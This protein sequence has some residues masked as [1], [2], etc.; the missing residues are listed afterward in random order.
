MLI[1]KK[2]MRG[3]D[4]PFGRPESG[5]TS[6][7]NASEGSENQNP[8][9]EV[10]SASEE[11]KGGESEWDDVSGSE[12]NQEA[13]NSDAEIESELHRMREEIQAEADLPKLREVDF[14]NAAEYGGS[15]I[16]ATFNAV[17]L[18]CASYLRLLELG[19]QVGG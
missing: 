9:S 5:K 1:E 8:G 17:N 10:E 11:N 3:W 2:Q 18:L 4:K 7:K 14:R 12:E 13:Q 15:F 16:E 19:A 6:H